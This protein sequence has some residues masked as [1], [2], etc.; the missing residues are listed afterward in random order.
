MGI[1]PDGADK[2]RHFREKYGLKVRL[3]SD[4]SH[5]VMES[6]GA[7]GEKTLY[8]RKSVGVIRSTVL[9]GPTAAWS[10]R[11]TTSVPTATPRRCSRPLRPEVVSPVR[12]A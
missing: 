1:S 2:H 10:G 9:V 12:S 5:E 6:Y 4:P 8:G 11:G 7:W 3:L